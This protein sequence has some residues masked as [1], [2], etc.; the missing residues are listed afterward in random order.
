[1]KKLAALLIIVGGVASATPIFLS[2]DNANQTSFGGETL[3]FTGTLTNTTAGTLFINGDVLNFTGPFTTDD[4]PFLTNAPFT[5]D[6][7]APSSDFQMFTVDIP[8][9]P[10][11]GLYTGSLLVQGGT[12]ADAMDSLGQ[13]TFSINIPTPEPSSAWLMLPALALLFWKRKH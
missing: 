5:I 13:A 10:A 11:P 6:P 1:M 7:S 12:T 2:F 8:V 4:S 9:L 3:S